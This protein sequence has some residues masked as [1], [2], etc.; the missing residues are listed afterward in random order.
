MKWASDDPNSHFFSGKLSKH[1]E[2]FMLLISAWFIDIS[3]KKTLFSCLF[4]HSVSFSGSSLSS[5]PPPRPGIRNSGPEVHILQLGDSDRAGWRRW[6]RY[7]LRRTLQ[8][9]GGMIRDKKLIDRPMARRHHPDFLG[10][11]VQ[12]ILQLFPDTAYLEPALHDCEDWMCVYPEQKKKRR[13]PLFVFFFFRYWHPQTTH[14][15]NKTVSCHKP[16]NR[17]SPASYIGLRGAVESNW[18]P[19]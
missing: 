4:P 2:D 3:Y 9:G 13:P 14:N 7:V 6:M 17:S 16:S 19:N 1:A 15:N 5:D 8:W 10:L 18:G 12:L 11:A